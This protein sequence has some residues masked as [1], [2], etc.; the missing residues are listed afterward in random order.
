M[1]IFTVTT[2]LCRV[3]LDMC[4]ICGFAAPSLIDPEMRKPVAIEIV[5]SDDPIRNENFGIACSAGSKA[6]SS[7]GHSSSWSITVRRARGITSSSSLKPLLARR[8]GEPLRPF[9]GI[10]PLG[11]GTNVA[12]YSGI[13]MRIYIE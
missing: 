10:L 6:P 1:D 12:C 9:F 11:I 7:S 8:P 3:D 4:N 5:I 13:R 2:R